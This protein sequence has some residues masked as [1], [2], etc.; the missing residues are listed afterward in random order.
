[1]TDITKFI[2]NNAG[3][4]KNTNSVWGIDNQELHSII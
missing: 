4:E 3:F 2:Q 1:M